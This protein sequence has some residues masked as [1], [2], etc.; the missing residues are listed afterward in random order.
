VIPFHGNEEA[1]KLLWRDHLSTVSGESFDV[2]ITTYEMVTAATSMLTHRNYSYVILDEAQRIKN[3][4][5]NIGQA[6]RKC[7]SVSKLLITGTPLQNDMHELWALLNWMFPDVFANSEQF[8]LA[9]RRH[10][11][12]TNVDLDLVCAA[13]KL[14]QP[15]MIRRLKKDVQTNLP[16]KTVLTIW[17]PITDM[18][19]FFYKRLLQSS[20]CAGQLLVGHD[21]GGGKEEN[22]QPAS[23]GGS[24]NKLM[25]LLMQLRKVVNHPYMF[26]EA[27]PNP[28]ET[29]ETIVTTS[30]KMMVLDRLLR[31]L[32]AEGHR[33]LVYSQF[34]SMLDVIQDYC[35]LVGHGFRR[36][37]GSTNLARRK[38]EIKMF[39]AKRGDQFVYLLSTRAGAL[40]ITLTGADTVIMYDSDWNPTWDKQAHDRVHRIGQDRP[41][42]IYQ[43][44]CKDT[45]EQRVFQRAAQKTSLNELV[46]RDDTESKSDKKE[47]VLSSTEVKKMLR[48]GVVKILEGESTVMT[49]ELVDNLI[50]EAHMRGEEDKVDPQDEIKED[51]VQAVDVFNQ[52]L[53][54]VRQFGGKV[55]D[56]ARDAY[57]DIA[58][59]WAA[60]IA[61]SSARRER[62]ST[63]EQVGAYQVLK[64]NRSQA[65]GDAQPSALHKE[66]PQVIHDSVC[67]YCGL[68]GGSGVH[69]LKT[70]KSSG[71][72]HRAFHEACMDAY[73]RMENAKR[74]T[75]IK[76]PLNPLAG[77]SCTQH[78]CSVCQAKASHKNG[79]IFRCWK[80]P[81]AFCGDCLPDEVS[82]V[83]ITH[84]LAAQCTLSGCLISH[85]FVWL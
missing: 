78:A 34:T 27:D 42:T 9:F 15:L 12:G 13:H 45:V 57:R 39:N 40:G 22:G 29:D 59:Q 72:C 69:A 33:V 5:S 54:E 84:H 36:L 8:D 64:I 10:F 20:G 73:L 66:K 67:L 79:V 62:V 56:N 25:N 70:C 63:V 68:R 37:D 3:E 58:S 46:L 38:Y 47:D 81:L 23:V 21:A 19:R 18:Q 2:I 16:K 48:C 11:L 14:L 26:P 52:K 49:E 82:P 41:V 60:E 44:L 30:A 43:L 6:V 32:K 75:M 76:K 17:C 53:L 31:K 7:R 4:M 80:C 83:P 71:R 1:R 50:N 65:A 51:D 77:L 24:K 35:S 85:H 74:D 28:L 61:A 55:F